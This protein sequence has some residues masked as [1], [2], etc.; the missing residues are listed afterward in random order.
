[1]KVDE[2]LLIEITETVRGC[3]GPAGTITA[4]AGR[5]AA[6]NILQSHALIKRMA[7]AVGLEV[8]EK[9]KRF[10]VERDG[11]FWTV[12]DSTTVPFTASLAWFTDIELPDARERAERLAAELNEKDGK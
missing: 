10:K 1:M 12:F 2:A 8:K 5:I 11:A 6:A 4:E 9:P 7:E 3:Y